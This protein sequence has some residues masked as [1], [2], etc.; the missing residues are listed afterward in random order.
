VTVFIVSA[1][2]RP[3]LPGAPVNITNSYSHSTWK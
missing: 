3:A 2:Y 1:P